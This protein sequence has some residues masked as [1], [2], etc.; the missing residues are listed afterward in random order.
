MYVVWVLH[1]FRLNV[2]HQSVDTVLF[3]NDFYCDFNKPTHTK[4]PDASKLRLLKCL[5]YAV[6]I[7]VDAGNVLKRIVVSE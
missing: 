7:Y 2:K 1:E 6:P 4:Y 5:G 3:D